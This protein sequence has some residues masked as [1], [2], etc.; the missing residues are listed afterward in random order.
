MPVLKDFWEEIPLL[1][2]GGDK[3]TELPINKQLSPDFQHYNQFHKSNYN[4]LEDF[5][6]AAGI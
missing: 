1:L 3:S 2:S 6:R 5:F 4:E